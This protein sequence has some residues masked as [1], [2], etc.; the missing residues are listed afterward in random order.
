M[1]AIFDLYAKTRT[2]IGKGASRRLR[3]TED[4]VPAENNGDDV[5]P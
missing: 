1:S 5:A 2:D 4:A 3:R